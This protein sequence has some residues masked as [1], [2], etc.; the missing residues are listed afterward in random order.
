MNFLA[1][2]SEIVTAVYHDVYE[3]LKIAVECS[4]GIENCVCATALM[5]R[6]KW[7]DP[8]DLR[9]TPKEKCYVGDPL[10]LLKDELLKMLEQD[11]ENLFKGFL[12]FTFNTDQPSPK[13]NSAGSYH[14][15][16]ARR[17]CEQWDRYGHGS[18]DEC[19]YAR[20]QE[21]CTKDETYRKFLELSGGQ[22][23]LD[24][25]TP[26]EEI[27]VA[28]KLVNGVGVYKE[29]IGMCRGGMQ[30]RLDQ[31][32]EGCVFSMLTGNPLANSD[33][34]R[35]G[36]CNGHKSEKLL[37]ELKNST[38]LLPKVRF[39]WYASPP[40]PPPQDAL[41]HAL[42]LEYDGAYYMELRQKMSEWY[43]SVQE[44]LQNKGNLPQEVWN[45][46]RSRVVMAIE[47]LD[48]NSI[49]A[50]MIASLFT[51]NWHHGCEKLMDELKDEANAK[52]G[53]DGEMFPYDR[54]ILLY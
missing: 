27:Q 22:A 40:P 36:L 13:K 9:A 26:S 12:H 53:Q 48:V 19:Y 42:I 52:A 49:A 23:D 16:E 45:M 30:I 33:A 46:Q 6:P 25:L 7:L 5:L 39:R 14:D 2:L 3:A 20:V 35:G 10:N 50:K 29:A 21:I 17:H 47:H 1:T 28:A 18:A 54:N 37:F 44:M 31:I 4:S 8:R 11:I 24:R 38:W 15:L 41:A 32:I 34:G 51:M 43:P